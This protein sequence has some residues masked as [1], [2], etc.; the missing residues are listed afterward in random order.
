[1]VGAAIRALRCHPVK[2]SAFSLTVPPSFL[3]FSFEVFS[4]FRCFEPRRRMRQ[5]DGGRS[6]LLFLLREERDQYARPPVPNPTAAAQ[7]NFSGF[8]AVYTLDVCVCACM[9]ARNRSPPRAFP[10]VE[11]LC[12]TLALRHTVTNLSGPRTCDPPELYAG[13]GNGVEGEGGQR[14]PFVKKYIRLATS[15]PTLNIPAPRID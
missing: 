15:A 14:S 5:T 1:M 13:N 6:S 4:R 3:S 12:R 8:A 10:F 9:C 2:L 7:F 11:A